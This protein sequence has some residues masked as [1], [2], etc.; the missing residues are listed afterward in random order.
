MQKENQQENDRRVSTW[1]VEE[2]ERASRSRQELKQEKERELERIF[3]LL[4]EDNEQVLMGLEE[5]EHVEGYPQDI[6]EAIIGVFSI[7]DSVCP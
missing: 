7:L 1:K 4:R 3:S 2:R 6:Q 5:G